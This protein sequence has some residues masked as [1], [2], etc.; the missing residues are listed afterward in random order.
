MIPIIVIINLIASALKLFIPRRHIRLVP[1]SSNLPVVAWRL[2]NG[3]LLAALG[4][5]V[6]LC[7][8]PMISASNTVRYFTDL[9][10]Y[11]MSLIATVGIVY[12]I[13]TSPQLVCYKIISD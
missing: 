7:I 1:T 10:T 12:I 4:V 13:W 5:L 9:F 11:G 6:A 3:I 8:T 2:I